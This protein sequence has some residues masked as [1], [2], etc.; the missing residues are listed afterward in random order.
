MATI[1]QTT[2]NDFQRTAGEAN[3]TTTGVITITP[4]ICDVLLVTLM[5]RGVDFST[6]TSVNLTTAPVSAL[7]FLV[8]AS[9]VILSGAG[10]PDKEI[11]YNDCYMA[12][13]SIPLNGAAVAPNGTFYTQSDLDAVIPNAATFD[14]AYI[15]DTTTY[16]TTQ[17]NGHA[18]V[19]LASGI[20]NASPVDGTPTSNQ[21][22][23][24]VPNVPNTAWGTTQATVTSGSDLLVFGFMTVTAIDTGT[25]LPPTDTLVTPQ[26]KV[27]GGTGNYGTA[28]DSRSTW[29]TPGTDLA[30]VVATFPGPGSGDQYRW[31]ST[32]PSGGV[33]ITYITLATAY[34]PGATTPIAINTAPQSN[35]V[36]INQ[37]ATFTAAAT[38]GVGAIAYQWQLSTD[39]GTTWNDIVG[40]TGSTYTTPYLLATDNGNQYRVIASDDD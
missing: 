37:Q 2:S 4:A 31:S 38:P 30:F 9:S 36:R 35:G 19:V 33:T 13:W 6:N 17:F 34:L 18:T 8:T 22:A 5:I 23:I 10:A 16:P 28:R 20:K 15:Y 40:A 39:G 1:K 29:T 25:G 7:Y 14:L 3:D 24:T 26:P 21:S 11:I 12:T 32:I 27:G